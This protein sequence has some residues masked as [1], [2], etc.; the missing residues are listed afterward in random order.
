MKTSFALCL[1]LVAVLPARAEIFGAHA[2]RA[3]AQRANEHRQ[4][5]PDHAPRHDGDRTSVHIGVGVGRG[6]G[7]SHHGGHFD[8]GYFHHGHRYGSPWHHG[9]HG[10]HGWSGHRGYGYYYSPYRYVPSYG[11]YSGY[12]YDYPYNT[13]YG[14]GYSR[15]ASAAANGLVLGALAG[16]IVGHN[17]GDLR[18]SAWR[19]AAWGA[20]LG[21][22]LGT[23]ADSRRAAT[24]H[25]SAPVVVQRAPAPSVQSAAQPQQVTIINNYYNNNSTPMSAANGMFG[26]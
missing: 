8:R 1:A 23:V 5:R 15:P 21:W 10:H 11:Y 16:G 25:D 24:Y 22:L 9:R 17:S 20:G 26:R 4:H 12:G 2:A 3:A 18:H 14:Y 19:G 7:R 13:D 6:H